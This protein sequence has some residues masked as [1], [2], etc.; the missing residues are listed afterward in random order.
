MRAKAVCA[1]VGVVLIIRSVIPA[2]FF[3]E[4][5]MP[6]LLVHSGASL[7]YLLG[8]LLVVPF[9]RRAPLSGLLGRVPVFVLTAIVTLYLIACAIMMIS[10]PIRPSFEFLPA[11]VVTI[12]GLLVAFS[13]TLVLLLRFRDQLG[14]WSGFILLLCSVGINLEMFSGWTITVLG[15]G[16]FLA[17]LARYWFTA[18]PM[19]LNA[20]KDTV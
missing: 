16:V 11:T 19:S 8:I 14:K 9:V 12:S 13:I 5:S 18:S 6:A 20:A 2:P 7:L 10:F 17:Q 1:L 15:V 3:L 4:T